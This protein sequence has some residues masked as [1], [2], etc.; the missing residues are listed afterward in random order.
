MK[1]QGQDLEQVKNKLKEHLAKQ[2]LSRF[3]R[4][5]LEA[6]G[7]QLL[8]EFDPKAE[9]TVQW[10]DLVGRWLVNKEPHPDWYPFVL[11]IPDNLM[12]PNLSDKESV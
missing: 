9:Y 12:I 8:D 11:E 3:Q 7:V 2:E 1:V 5:I 6:N 10:N 4:T